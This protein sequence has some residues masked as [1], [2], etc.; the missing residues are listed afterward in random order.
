MSCNNINHDHIGSYC[1]WDVICTYDHWYANLT[2][3]GAEAIRSPNEDG[4][5]LLPL[6]LMET[7]VEL[8]NYILSYNI[9]YD[10]I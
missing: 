3:G 8:N 5:G 9:F 2:S 7:M 4:R 1:V 6:D 10:Y